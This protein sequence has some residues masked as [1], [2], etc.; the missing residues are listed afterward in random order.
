MEIKINFK[1]AGKEIIHVFAPVSDS[2]EGLPKKEPEYVARLRQVQRIK[3]SNECN[4]SWCTIMDPYNRNW[5]KYIADLGFEYA[6]VWGEGTWP[7]FNDLEEKVIEWAPTEDN[8]VVAGQILYRNYVERPDYPHFYPS[9]IIIN[10]KEYLRAGSPNPVFFDDRDNVRTPAFRVSEEHIHDNYTPLWIAPS[11]VQLKKDYTFKGQ[12]LDH[13]IPNTIRKGYRVINIPD[14]IRHD[15]HSCYPEE[16]TEATKSWLLDTEFN[17]GKTPQQV[18]E[19]GYDLHEDKMELYGYKIQQFQVLYV[20]N[21]ESIPRRP[22]N[23]SI[24]KHVVP[25]SGLHQFWHIIQDVD[26]LERVCWYDFNPYA[27]AWTKL[28]LN[29]WDGVNFSEFYRENIDRVIGDGVIAK[30]CVIY[31]PDLYEKLI[32]SLGGIDVFLERWQRVQEIKHEF[33]EINVVKDW[34]KFAGW[35]GGSCDVHLQLTNIWQYESNYLNT[36]AYTAQINFL[37]LI[38]KLLK[39]NNNLYFTGNTPG[40]D[41]YVY[42]DMRL[43]MEID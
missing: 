10:L 11:D 13:L 28:V 19:F 41:H 14:D 23:I 24:S 36:D 6:L 39:H 33:M 22:K 1:D 4:Y 2:F 37:S 43:F 35:I 17:T 21:T 29:E 9:L 34:E 16:D 32:E 30:D 18:K 3:L 27:I 8:W 15:K 7:E 5:V 12:Y 26:T 42:K 20:T 25:C 31:D 38:R 40:G